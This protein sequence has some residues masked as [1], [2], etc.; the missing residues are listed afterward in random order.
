MA[1]RNA[2]LR[3]GDIVVVSKAGMVYVVGELTRGGG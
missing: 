1:A 3:P 2:V